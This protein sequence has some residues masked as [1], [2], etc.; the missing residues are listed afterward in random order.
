MKKVNQGFEPHGRAKASRLLT[1]T[2]FVSRWTCIAQP[3][4]FR[5]GLVERFAAHRTPLEI[6]NCAL[7]LF[8]WLVWQFE[9]V[10]KDK[11]SLLLIGAV[12]AAVVIPVQ[13]KVSQ[14]TL[15]NLNTAFQGESNAAHRYEAFAKTADSEGHSQAARLFRAAAKAETIHKENHKQAILALGGK[16]KDFKLDEL[17]VGTTA[18]NLWAAIKGESYERDTMYP[19]FLKQAKADGSKEATRT[20]LYAEKAEAEHAKLYQEALDSLGQ[21]RDLSIFVCK[22]CGYTT[23]KLPE[24]N[25]PSCRESVS[26][27]ERIN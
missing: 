14:Q 22:V 20:L 15:D 12:L 10:M 13:A 17:K 16:V 24:R 27:F 7:T 18:E 21:R 26:D 11:V 4:Q 1:A 3:V 23:T 6:S 2:G 5:Q 19:D 25:C 8:K 9:R